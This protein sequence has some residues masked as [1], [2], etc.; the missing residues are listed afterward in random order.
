MT[1]P[2]GYQTDAGSDRAE[3][4]IGPFYFKRDGADYDFAFLAAGHHC[5]ANNIVHGGVLMTFADYGLCMVASDGY[6]AESCLTVSFNCEFVAATE[7][8]QIV[9][10]RAEIVRKT[11][12]MVFVRGDISAAGQVVMNFSA[13][14]KRLLP[15]D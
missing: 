2:A 7:A 11:G 15:R 8:G 10:C 13:V 6:Q 4:H 1:F 14:V 12:S 9:S 5:N 3:D